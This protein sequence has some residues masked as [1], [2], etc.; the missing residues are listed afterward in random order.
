[1]SV[2]SQIIGLEIEFKICR[3]FVLESYFPFPRV[4]LYQPIQ[5]AVCHLLFFCELPVLQ[6]I[7]T[8]VFWNRN[9]NQIFLVVKFLSVSFL[10]IVLLLFQNV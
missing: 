2:F 7:S 4:S 9:E 6:R 8:I 1:M 3:D 10:I 5:Q